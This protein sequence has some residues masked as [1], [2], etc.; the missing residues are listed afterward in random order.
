[1]FTEFISNVANN[2]TMFT[3]FVAMCV[4]AVMI[5]EIDIRNREISVLK[6][7]KAALE[8]DADR[9]RAERDAAEERCEELEA[10]KEELK[11]AM[12][13]DAHVMQARDELDAERKARRD[14]AERFEDQ[15]H[16][17]NEIVVVMLVFGFATLFIGSMLSLVVI[18]KSSGHIN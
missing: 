13:K 7:E 18:L 1:M 8:A 10:D 11:D 12:D 16:Q 15:I 2:G 9:I 17:K 14:D 6:G 4:F 5:G 3:A